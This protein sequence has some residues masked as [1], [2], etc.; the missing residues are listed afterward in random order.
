MKK[1]IILLLLILVGCTEESI[2]IEAVIA[3][4]MGSTANFSVVE[5][6]SFKQYGVNEEQPHNKEFSIDNFIEYDNNVIYTATDMTYETT[7]QSNEERGNYN[8]TSFKDLLNNKAYV[9]PENDWY[10]V[11][12]PQMFKLEFGSIDPVAIVNSILFDNTRIVFKG[13]KAISVDPSLYRVASADLSSE[14]FES[15]FSSTIFKFIDVGYDY[16]VPVTMRFNEKYQ[17]EYIDFDLSELQRAYS[18]YHVYELK[19]TINFI[20]SSYKLT[21]DNYGEVEIENVDEYINWILDEDY[22]IERGEGLTGITIGEVKAD[23]VYSDES[24]TYTTNVSIELNEDITYMYYELYFYREGQILKSYYSEYYNILEYDDLS[25]YYLESDVDVDEVVFVT[26]YISAASS[27]IIDE[28]DLAQIYIEGP[29][30]GVDIDFSIY[31]DVSTELVPNVMVESLGIVKGVS[32]YEFTF[33]LYALQD[34]RNVDVSI[35]LYENGIP[36]D[37]IEIEDITVNQYKD[38]VITKMLTFEPDEIYLDL[39]YKTAYLW[40]NEKHMKLEGH[41]IEDPMDFSEYNEEISIITYEIYDSK[42]YANKYLVSFDFPTD[43]D[44]VDIY[45]YLVDVDSNVIAWERVY[46]FNVA[47]DYEFVTD[48]YE[49]SVDK[50]YLEVRADETLYKII[51]TYGILVQ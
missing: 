34:T 24:E 31:N 45:L 30:H 47:Q 21:F 37:I 43:I 28:S 5:E 6:F 29:I 32:S 17:V 36:K 1:F 40:F 41:S 44:I 3:Q 33:D 7:F 11:E 42:W 26:R 19:S 8:F 20:S 9:R 18:D 38:H 51:G 49:D 10:A 2:Q 50:I 46:D 13:D 35:L 12:L 23:V 15:L 16:T 27:E 22:Q 4:E 39:T 25:L 48:L 14:V